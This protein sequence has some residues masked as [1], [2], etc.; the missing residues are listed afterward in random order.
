MFWPGRSSL[1]MSTVDIYTYVLK[2]DIAIYPFILNIHIDIAM[3]DGIY[4]PVSRNGRTDEME[5]RV[6]LGSIEKARPWVMSFE[7]NHGL[8][9]GNA[10]SSQ[11]IIEDG[12]QWV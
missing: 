3:N 12:V 9:R 8:G 6:W 11:C 10:R 5:C 4:S 7:S 2:V 1:V